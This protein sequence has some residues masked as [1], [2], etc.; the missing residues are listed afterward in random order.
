MSEIIHEFLVQGSEIAPYKVVFKK[1]GPNLKAT[2]NCRA[3]MN[4]LLCKHRLSIL[5]G[6]TKAVVSDNTD[7]VHEIAS[8]LTGSNL[9]NAIS[10]VVALEVEKKAIDEK[11]K[12]AKKIV[13]AELIP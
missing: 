1:N 2:C 10:E 3:G 8:W 4:R 5:D 6:D 13:A 7:Q 11:I 12:R 9:G